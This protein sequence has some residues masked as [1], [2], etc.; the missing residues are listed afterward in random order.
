MTIC[1]VG[2]QICFDYDKLPREIK[3]E[4]FIKGF[5]EDRESGIKFD[6]VLRHVSFP[7]VVVKRKPGRNLKVTGTA[8]RHDMEFFFQ[9]LYKK[10]CNVSL[11]FPEVER[12]LILH[13]TGRPPHHQSD[14]RRHLD[15]GPWR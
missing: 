9:W 1:T 15:P 4:T 3:E 6:E 10:V 14:R 7:E 2:I 8:G 11:P 5:G 12:E 13:A